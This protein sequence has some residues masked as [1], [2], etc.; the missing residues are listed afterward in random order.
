MNV[1]RHAARA[2]VAAMFRQHDSGELDGDGTLLAAVRRKLCVLARKTGS[3]DSSSMYPLYA[4]CAADVTPEERTGFLR[5][6]VRTVRRVAVDHMRD[7]GE[8]EQLAGAGLVVAIDAALDRVERINPALVRVAECCYFGGLSETE[9]AEAMNVDVATLRRL[10]LRARA[11]TLRELS[12]DTPRSGSAD[13]ALIDAV[14]DDALTLPSEKVHLILERCSRAPGGLRITVEELLVW[15]AATKPRFEPGDLSA[16]FLRSIL[17]AAAPPIEPE[18]VRA[19][20]WS[21]V[22]EL[23]QGRLGILYLARKAGPQEKNN[24][25]PEVEGALRWLPPSV[26]ASAAE[27]R[28]RHEWR[29]LASLHDRRIARVLEAGDDDNGRIYVVSE[30]ADG[31]PI[32]DYCAQEALTIEQRLHLFVRLC[33]AVQHAHRKLAVHGAIRPSTVVVTA[34]GDLRLLDCG[35]PYLFGAPSSI[36]S[37][38]DQLGAL[39][40][41]LSAGRRHAD[42][43]AIVARA[44]HR[45]PERRYQ[46]VGLL[47]SDVQRYLARRPVSARDATVG[48]RLARFVVRRR[49]PLAIA[50]FFVFCVF[51]VPFVLPS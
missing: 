49:V 14:L 2:T 33:G 47:R 31:R 37:D 15:A 22:R 7:A 29:A 32:D 40:S 50:L 16:E 38:V 36:A 48:Y 34:D 8:R 11:W 39:L 44:R 42:L 18:E 17:A 43:E 12:A 6:C 28:A 51:L 4:A 19:G 10:W 27:L 46:S 13:H 21:V 41:A 26:A 1:E 20:P 9:A 3:N 25:T 30:L 35:M 5:L 23:H 45:D 24:G